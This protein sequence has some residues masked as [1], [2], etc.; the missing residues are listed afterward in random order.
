VPPPN[1]IWTT[2]VCAD[3]RRIRLAI[4]P[5]SLFPESKTILILRV[6]FD[7]LGFSSGCLASRIFWLAMLHMIAKAMSVP[8]PMMLNVT[9][10][11]WMP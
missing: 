10:R 6:R 3:F 4:C 11:H 9:V 8:I 5:F 2:Q 1:L 7:H